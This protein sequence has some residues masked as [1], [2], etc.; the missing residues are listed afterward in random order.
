MPELP[1]EVVEACEVWGVECYVSDKP[2]AILEIVPRPTSG[3]DPFWPVAGRAFGCLPHARAIP[4][5]YVIAHELGHLLGLDHSTDPSNLMYPTTGDDADISEAQ[6]EHVH[7]HRGIGLLR[8][9]A[10]ACRSVE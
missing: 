5:A 1:A 7:S 6:L 10:R 4:H 9:K 3:D 8:R 2:T